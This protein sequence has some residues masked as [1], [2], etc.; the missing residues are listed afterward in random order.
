MATSRLTVAEAF[1]DSIAYTGTSG[2]QY[3]GLTRGTNSIFNKFSLFRFHKYGPSYT[4]YNDKF[5]YDGANASNTPAPDQDNQNKFNSIVSQAGTDSANLQYDSPA[6]QQLQ[7]LQAQNFAATG[8]TNITPQLAQPMSQQDLVTFQNPTARAIIQ[9]AQEDNKIWGPTPYSWTDFIYCKFNGKIPNNRLVT[10]RRFPFPVRDNLKTIGGQNVIP[11]SQA[12]TWFGEATENP[13]SSIIPG[14]NWA[15][16]FKMLDAHDSD[17]VVQGNNLTISEVIT[18]LGNLPAGIGTGV[19]QLTNVLKGLAGAM[20]NVNGDRAQVDDLSGRYQ[21]IQD[22]MKND[23]YSATGPYWNQILGGVNYITQTMIRD[24]FGRDREWME[25]ISLNFHYSLRS[26]N[27]VKPKIAMLDLISNFLSLTFMNMEFKGNF[28]RFFRNAGITSNI[29]I[30]EQISKLAQENR[31]VE[32]LQLIAASVGH[33]VLSATGNSNDVRTLQTGLNNALAGNS[34]SSNL[35]KA[36]NGY[37]TATVAQNLAKGPVSMRSTLSD[38][39]TGEWHLVI[40]NPIEPIAT[41]GNLICTGCKMKFGEELGPDDF[42][43][44]VTFTVKLQ[45]AKPRDKYMIDSM[46]NLGNGFLTENPIQPPLSGSASNTFSSQQ[47]A[48]NAA[49]QSSSTA[50]D[51]QSAYQNGGISADALTVQQRLKIAYGSI[52]SDSGILPLYFMDT[53]AQSANSKQNSGSTTM[54]GASTGG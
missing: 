32:A 51:I 2:Q 14:L 11:I 5:M 40:G 53:T 48:Q 42:P 24:K 52:Y 46:F 18:A 15:M 30:D 9:W 43:T 19:Q 20:Y 28:T 47:Q 27:N 44:E 54:N 50:N 35:E 7:A 22:F 3:F 25:P 23:L 38:A 12:V 4:T 33:D 21:K 37:I 16:P 36:I 49:I 1:G 29:A 17:L 34:I 41:I 6:N 45:M 26:F 8:S 10:L 13:L 31:W 39:E